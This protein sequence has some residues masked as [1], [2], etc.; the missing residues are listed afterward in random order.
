MKRIDLDTWNRKTAYQNFIGYT[1]PFFSLS[2]RLDI[3]KLL[4]F[5]KENKL[6]FFPTFLYVIIKCANSVEEMRIRI[7]D[8]NVALFDV[9]HP[10]YIVIRE[11]EE[12]VTQITRFS[13]DFETFHRDVKTDI[14]LVKRGSNQAFNTDFHA[15]CYYISCLPWADITSLSHPY[16]MNNPTACSIPRITWGKYVTDAN[17]VSTVHF[18]I[19]AHHA[20]IDGRQVARVFERIADALSHIEEFIGGE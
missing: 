2:T 3:T 5:C 9:A 13:E 1:H 8:E 4:A 6:G 19:A 20:L 10:S 7:V 17:G 16:D 14:E 12:L 11:N 15:D 18:D